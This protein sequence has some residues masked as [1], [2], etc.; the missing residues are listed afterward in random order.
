MT[1]PAIDRMTCREQRLQAERLTFGILRAVET[2]V[3]GM[4]AAAQSGP[5]HYSATASGY[6]FRHPAGGMWASVNLEVR[7]TDPS[8]TTKDRRTGAMTVDM[9]RRHLSGTA[10]DLMTLTADEA[11][12]LCG[13][14][15]L[16]PY[17]LREWCD[18]FARAARRSVR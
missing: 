13:T 4:L 14:S 17:A 18:E 5:I 15:R 2:R 11:A 10:F 1:A 16:L 8:T 6:T 9:P 7:A 3:L 12:V